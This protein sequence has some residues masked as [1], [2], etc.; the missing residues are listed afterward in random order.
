MPISSFRERFVLA[1]RRLY[2]SYKALSIRIVIVTVLSSFGVTMN[3][4]INAVLHSFCYIIVFTNC[5][6]L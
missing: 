6:K 3:F 4:S 5:I 2:S 1:A